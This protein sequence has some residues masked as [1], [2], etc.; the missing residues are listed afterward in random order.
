M[1]RLRTFF[2]SP[3]PTI[4][5]YSFTLIL[6]VFACWKAR[7]GIDLFFVLTEL[8]LLF[9]A[10][11]ALARR[12]QIAA[13]IVNSIFIFLIDVQMLLLIFGNSYLS[14]VMVTNLDSL[15]DLSGK[16]FVYVGAVLVMA[17]FVLMPIRHFDL[18]PEEEPA[19]KGKHL[20]V[21]PITRAKHLIEDSVTP[22][23]RFPFR[24]DIAGIVLVVAICAEAIG[25][26]VFGYQKSPLGAY[27]R[28][29]GEYG[30]NARMAEDLKKQ[31][32]TTLEF[33]K[34]GVEGFVDKPKSLPEKPNIVLVFCEG[35]SQNVIDDERTIMPNVRSYQQK[36]L[37]FTNYYNHTFA[38]YRG[39]TG[40]LYSGYQRENFDTNT[41]ISLPKILE[42]QGYATRFINVETVN[43]DFYDYLNELG[44]QKVLDYPEGAHSG[45][46]KGHLS[47]KESYQKLF[48]EMNNLSKEDRP[49]FLS[50][51]TVGTH[52]SFDAVDQR[53]GSGEDSELNKFFDTDAQFGE[54]MKQFEASPL[55]ENTIVVFT[56]DHCTYADMYYSN[57]FPDYERPLVSADSIPLFIY[58]KDVSPRQVDVNGR[59]SLD[60]APTLLDFL[61]VSAPNYFIGSSLFAPQEQAPKIESYFTDSSVKG[62][63]TNSE[64]K[65]VDPSEVQEQMDIVRNYYAAK[66]Q[67]PLTPDQVSN[68]RKKKESKPRLIDDLD[69]QLPHTQ[70]TLV[71]KRMDEPATVA[72]PPVPEALA[73]AIE[74]RAK[75]TAYNY[76]DYGY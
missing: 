9:F 29:A 30:E 45:I 32:N 11:N 58:Y 46:V 55:R 35:L 51:Y 47:D 68:Y 12:S 40:Q 7:D 2:Q 8:T 49:F 61:D 67:E 56:T 44:Y 13:N 17:I 21:D 39:L 60:M 75:E 38:T 28:L 57:S 62:T 43:R 64:V 3:L 10:C 72:G 27:I 18:T 71:F 23:K 69:T 59:N 6:A 34:E 42:D 52:A 31:P 15:E 36:S 65:R 48:E 20:E 73:K 76:G 1:S 26:G 63:T 53:F 50:M 24:L 4:I 19:P 74:A 37:S 5:K 66:N 16:V 70:S 25:I 54:F 22:K 41:L 14:L 33:Y